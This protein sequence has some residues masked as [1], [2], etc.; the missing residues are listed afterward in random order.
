MA[1]PTK[2]TSSS[3]GGGTSVPPPRVASTYMGDFI[4]GRVPDAVADASS[5]PKFEASEVLP[6]AATFT[7]WSHPNKWEFLVT[8]ARPQGEWLPSL[9]EFRIMPGANRVRTG[10]AMNLARTSM[11]DWEF[12]EIPGHHGPGGNYV[13]EYS[14]VVKPKGVIKRIYLSA[15]DHIQVLGKDAVKVFD[16]AGFRDWKRKLMAAGVIAPP[17][18]YVLARMVRQKQARIQR[19]GE[20]AKDN[21]A[22]RTRIA[23]EVERMS[24][25]CK[26]F[27]DQFGYDPIDP[28]SAI[29]AFGREM[30]EAS[31][32]LPDQSGE[33]SLG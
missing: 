3:N 28:E 26:S 5:L 24:I 1:V 22:S 23:K 2:R 27:A 6:Y 20:S 9:T 7:F 17:R 19:L 10:G 15:W 13:R 25:M 21:E 29:E 12:A 33:E 18:H 16:H 11:I 31:G 14:V 30:A 8:K 4:Q 32:A